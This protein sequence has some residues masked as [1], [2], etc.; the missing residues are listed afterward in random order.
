M[1]TTAVSETIHLRLT[2]HYAFAAE[3]VFR[4]WT[5]PEA[6]KTWFAPDS[7][8]KVEIA[9][10]DLRVGGRYR[11]VMKSPDGEFF[12]VGGTYLDIERPHRLAFTWAW[13]SKPEEESLVTVELQSSGQGTE[14]TLTHERFPDEG[15]R[16][17]HEWGWN[18]SLARLAQ[19]HI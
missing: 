19:I 2:R 14:L 8:Y 9:E 7:S 12:R 1:A 15:S 5:E 13:E 3:T 6:L 11:L 16:E 17:R 18:G 10:V 4:A